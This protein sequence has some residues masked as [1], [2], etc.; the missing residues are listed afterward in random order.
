MIKIIK[1][2]LNID[3]LDYPA[4]SILTLINQKYSDDGIFLSSYFRKR[5]KDSKLDNCLTILEYE[6]ENEKTPIQ[7]LEDD[8]KEVEKEIVPEIKAVKIAKSKKQKRLKSK[9]D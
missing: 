5:I 3:M 6:I 7:E 1:V 4:G 2:K 8:Y 9:K